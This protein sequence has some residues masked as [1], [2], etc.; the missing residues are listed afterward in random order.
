MTAK[1]VTGS[2]IV[3]K[4]Q[5]GP[6]YFLKARDRD[7][8]QIKHRLGP[9]ADWPQKQAQDALRDFLTDLGRVPDRGDGSVTFEY[10]ASSWLHY[11]EHDKDRAPSTVR[12][13]RSTVDH[14]LSPRFGDRALSEITVADIEKLR[15]DLLATRSRRTGQKTLILLHGIFKLAVR[16]EWMT[17][18]PVAHVE[19]VGIRRRTEFAV[20]T[21]EEVMA[22]ARVAPTEQD[23][24]LITVAAFTGLR[25]GELRALRW[26]DVAWSKHYVHV[27][28]SYTG[29][30]EK[31]PKSGK[32]RSVP[33][34]D[35]VA[36]ALDALSKREHSIGLDDRVFCS[37]TG[38][39]LDDGQIRDMFYAALEHAGIDRDRGTGK[40]L[41]FH[42]LRHTFGT[43]VVEKFPLPTVQ[44]WMGHSAIATTMLYVHHIDKHDEADALSSLI[45]GERVPA[46]TEISEPHVI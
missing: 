41:V 18:N 28:R 24:A 21:V 8:C 31:T 26:R 9:V 34:S 11:I 23:A 20:L 32:A 14:H 43:M 13:Y 38:G 1:R 35:P 30:G 45:E 10:A 25:L 27:R 12:D 2:L 16:R 36:R 22:L 6:V 39:V 15:R 19:R 37:A 44:A 5:A 29:T 4:R 33:L 17:S 40:L 7:G 3:V 42:D 46:G